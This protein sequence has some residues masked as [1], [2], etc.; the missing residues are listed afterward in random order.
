MPRGRWPR[1]TWQELVT[2]IDPEEAAARIGAA[3]RADPGIQGILCT[4]LADMM[5]AAH[6]VEGRVANTLHVAGFDVAP[7]VLRQI[8]VGRIAFTIDQQP[9]VQGFY[10]VAQL[11]L[12]CRYGIVPTDIDAGAAVIG[13]DQV[14]QVMAASQAGYR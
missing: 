10:P 9:Y 13:P 1:I 4:G 3:L 11:T 2:G 6:V 7:E 5:G 14:D 12:Y 8:K